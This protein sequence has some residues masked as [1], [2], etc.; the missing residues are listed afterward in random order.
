MLLA[1]L[2]DLVS[3]FDDIITGESGSLKRLSGRN[4]VIALPPPSPG[5]LATPVAAMHASCAIMVVDQ[6]L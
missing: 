2:S 4:S 5:A 1:V 6:S 3:S